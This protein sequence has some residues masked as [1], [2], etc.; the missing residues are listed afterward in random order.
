M[1]QLVEQRIRNAWVGGSS[2]PGGSERKKI[3]GLDPA[4]F[5]FIVS[6]MKSRCKRLIF[7]TSIYVYQTTI[8]I[9]RTGISVRMPVPNFTNIRVIY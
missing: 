3:A 6:S 2:P 4:I 7:F 5:L 9:K 8:N 1:A